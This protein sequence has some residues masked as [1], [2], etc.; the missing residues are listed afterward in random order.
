M[1]QAVPH[2]PVLERNLNN[3]PVT[4]N[5]W[6]DSLTTFRTAWRIKSPEALHYY[7][8]THQ[9]ILKEC[10]N[11]PTLSIMD[12]FS[13]DFL[14]ESLR[15]SIGYKSN[16]APYTSAQLA[17]LLKRRYTPLTLDPRLKKGEVETKV[18]T[19]KDADDYLALRNARFALVIN[20]L[21]RNGWTLDRGHEDA[22][23]AQLLAHS[24][25]GIPSLRDT[26]FYDPAKQSYIDY[27][28][29]VA[30]NILM[31]AQ[32]SD[33]SRK[34]NIAFDFITSGGYWN[35][36][37]F[38]GT[39]QQRHIAKNPVM[40]SLIEVEGALYPDTPS[41]WIKAEIQPTPD[42]VTEPKQDST[43]PVEPV[44][45]PVQDAFGR[46]KRII[47][48]PPSR[49]DRTVYPPLPKRIAKSEGSGDVVDT[50]LGNEVLINGSLAVLKRGGKPY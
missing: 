1:T 22:Q 37:P 47:V 28:A 4:H 20:K 17:P 7:T 50:M 19:P 21:K 29:L 12:E 3:L 6:A 33:G 46:D 41:R 38:Y 49:F 30:C 27:H 26:N 35:K 10:R 34:N 25:I 43:S 15:D 44:P 18:Y 45:E 48:Q 13:L 31:Q 9:A 40:K 23:M 39:E 16:I 14:L 36:L 11:D 2:N 5:I 8:A 32:N 42:P 24:M